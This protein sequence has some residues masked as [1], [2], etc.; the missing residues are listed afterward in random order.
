MKR[1]FAA[2]KVTPEPG[3]V[4]I[5]QEIRH[6][7]KYE[8]ITW[9]DPSVIHLTLK[10]FGETEES[11]IPVIKE[12]LKTAVAAS[13]STLIRIYKTGIFGSKYDPKVI[14]FGIDPNEA[15]QKLAGNVLN[16]LESAGWER[17]RQ[18]F[19]PH[20]TIGRIRELKDKALFQEVISNYRDRFI[21]EQAV[22]E[23]HLYESILRKEGPLYLKMATFQ[24]PV[25]H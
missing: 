24:L 15:L 20:L 16:E 11:K 13:E 14:W 23:I 18:N 22:R 25:S 12:S 9:V 17:D 2:I 6:N 3:F 21:Q 7:L 19:V 10:F 4:A 8:R 1:L 5:L